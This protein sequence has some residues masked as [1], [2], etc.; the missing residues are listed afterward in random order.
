M[1]PLRMCVACRNRREKEG[2]IRLVAGTEGNVQIDETGKLQ[3]RGTYLCRDKA[4]VLGAKKRRAIERLFP[5]ADA[6]AV[7]AKLLAEWEAEEREC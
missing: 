1:K 4:C 6:T 2:L 5:K 7:Y 3:G